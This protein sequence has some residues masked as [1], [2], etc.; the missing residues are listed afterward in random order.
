MYSVLMRVLVALT[1]LPSALLVKTLGLFCFN[2][3]EVARRPRGMLFWL[4]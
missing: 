2:L 3:T 4:W 1:E